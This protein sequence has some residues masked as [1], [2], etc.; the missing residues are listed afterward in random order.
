MGIY[1]GILPYGHMAYDLDHMGIWHVPICIWYKGIKWEFRRIW[2]YGQMGIWHMAQL[3]RAYGMFPYVYGI[4]A[5]K[6]DLDESG[7]MGKRA[8]GIWHI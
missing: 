8:Y 5:L 7:H 4:N 3:I 1:M 6:E 2:A